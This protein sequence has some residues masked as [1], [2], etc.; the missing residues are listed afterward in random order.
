MSQIPPGAIVELIKTGG[1]IG[2]AVLV[3]VILILLLKY[4]VPVLR[5][6]NGGFSAAIATLPAEIKALTAA[7]TAHMEHAPTKLQFAKEFEKNRHDMAATVMKGYD[8]IQE[9]I[10][11]LRTS[12]KDRRSLK[13]GRERRKP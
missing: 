7:I 6:I 2:G 1:I 9:E 10:A 3:L 8:N 11:D 13:R 12:K 5:P 4:L